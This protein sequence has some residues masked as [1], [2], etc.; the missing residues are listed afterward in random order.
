[1]NHTADQDEDMEVDKNMSPE[2]DVAAPPDGE[3]S[4]PPRMPEIEEPSSPVTLLQGHEAE[5]NIQR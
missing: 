4:D 3:P 5:V 1:M 2:H